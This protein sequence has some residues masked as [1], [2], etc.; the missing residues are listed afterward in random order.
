MSAFK[1]DQH[2]EDYLAQLRA[3]WEAAWAEM[4]PEQQ[5]ERVARIAA[6]FASIRLR[7]ARDRARQV[8]P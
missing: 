5:E 7:Q 8:K 2:R 6:L 1:D 4:T 3:Q